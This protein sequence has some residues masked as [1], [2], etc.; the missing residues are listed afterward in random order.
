[1]F[2]CADCNKSFETSKGRFSHWRQV[3]DPERMIVDRTGE[4]S[5]RF[6]CKGVNQYTGLD[7]S[8]V[9]WDDLGGNSRRKRLLE[10][11]DYACTQCK[12]NKTRADG[13]VILEIDHIDGNHLNNTRENLRVLCPNCH[14]L[15]PNFRNWGRTKKKTS[16]RI[17]KG[18]SNYDEFR[19]RC[20]KSKQLAIEKLI[21]EILQ[22]H[23]T[24]QIKLNQQGWVCK[25]ANVVNFPHQKLRKF[26]QKHMLEFYEANCWDISNI[27]HHKLADVA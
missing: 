22:V 17:R 4:N 23:E 21:F 15:T 2:E 16:T 6:G 12:F 14:A 24:K 20:A 7:W 27:K 10:E 26:M 8:T 19:N 18:N 1:M 11:T 25:L 13:G 5:P 3:H 9:A